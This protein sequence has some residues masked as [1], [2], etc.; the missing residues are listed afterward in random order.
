MGLSN[1]V[2]AHT[3]AEVQSAI[4]YASA[5]VESYCERS[6]AQV[7]DDVVVLDPYYG[8]LTN[9]GG[10]GSDSSY[11]YG[12]YPVFGSAGF[13]GVGSYGGRA[14]LP[15]PPVTGVAKL[16]GFLPETW[17]SGGS[18]WE[19]GWIELP[20]FN[21]KEDGLI[22]DTSMLP[23][24]F[25]GPEPS[26]P[27]MPGSLRATYDHGYVLPG[28]VGA[29]LPEGVAQAVIKAIAR[30]LVN[31]EGFTNYKVGDVS[32][33]FNAFNSDADRP[34]GGVVDELLLGRYRLVSL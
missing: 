34:G 26:W 24:N 21:W 16:E 14:L 18:G 31:P 25:N 6:F 8:S 4:D 15:N 7:V 12:G 27:T 13:S 30:Y 2:G 17:T 1:I 23:G 28:E 29:N 19:M 22:F 20:Y 5:A 32:F 10:Y 9:K 33:A 11:S 3:A